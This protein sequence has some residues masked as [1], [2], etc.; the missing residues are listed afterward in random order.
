L[1]KGFPSVDLPIIDPVL[2][3]QQ[4]PTWK[5]LVAAF[6]KRAPNLLHGS[7]E[8]NNFGFASPRTWD[9]AAHLLA[10]CHLLGHSPLD[11]QA[12]T[13]PTMQLLTGALGEGTTIAF[14]NFVQHIRLPD[15]A[16]VLDGEAEVDMAKL[17]DGEVYVLFG[18]LNNIL[19]ERLADP[20][21]HESVIRYFGLLEA[22]FDA[23]KRDL[24][25]V[26]MKQ[27]IKENLLVNALATA[28]QQDEDA[29]QRIIT[30]MQTLF[31]DEGLNE[32][33]DILRN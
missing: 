24:V 11:K 25:Y 18:T 14:M 31:S 32:F 9:Y 1:S 5:L 7:P 28:Q 10:S 3:A 17:N 27:I 13:T 21:L 6:L 22:V 29:A 15:P 19:R 2:H 8:E 4:L 16:E 20:Q 33:I 26:P 30:A 12:D 23:G